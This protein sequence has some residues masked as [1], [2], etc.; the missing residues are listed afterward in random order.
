MPYVATKPEVYEGTSV[1]SGQC[2]ALVQQAAGAPTT[3]SWSKGGFVKG[4]ATL[5]RGTVIATFDPNGRYGNHTDGR[6]HA[7]IY[8]GQT[9]DGIQVIDQWVSTV[10]GKAVPHL[11]SE[12]TIP[13]RG[14]HG[15]AVNDGDQFYVVR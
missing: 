5:A 3:P 4:D 7:A 11:A 6:S 12:R 15:H 1:G 8:L 2:V 10:H 13:F 14:G 9:K